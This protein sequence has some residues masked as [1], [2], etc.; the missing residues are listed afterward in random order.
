MRKQFFPLVAI[1]AV[2]LSGCDGLM[3]PDIEKTKPDDA[4]KLVDSLVY[5]KSNK[6]ICFG[7]TTTSRM[8][9]SGAVA[10]SQLVVPIE[11]SKVGL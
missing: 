4:Q 2:C 11:C 9:T 3:T 8:N 7:V 10:Y 1:L 5:V 6:G